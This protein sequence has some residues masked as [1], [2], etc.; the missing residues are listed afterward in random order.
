M[1]KKSAAFIAQLS[2]PVLLLIALALP[3]VPQTQDPAAT[4]QR[5][6]KVFPKEQ[7]PE[8]V[9]RFDIKDLR[10]KLK[11]FVKLITNQK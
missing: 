2:L 11:F 7:D 6:R 4:S 8:D 9:L 3:G 5:P 1:P 10:N